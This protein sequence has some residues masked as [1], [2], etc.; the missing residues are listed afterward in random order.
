MSDN[1]QTVLENES[2]QQK[3]LSITFLF[4]VSDLLDETI[5]FESP[6]F[7]I[8]LAKEDP[9]KPHPIIHTFLNIILKYSQ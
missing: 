8:A 4:I 1:C 9:I 7:F 2:P 3:K 6:F 5:L